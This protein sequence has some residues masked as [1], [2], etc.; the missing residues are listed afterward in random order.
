MQVHKQDMDGGINSTWRPWLIPPQD[1]CLWLQRPAA[2]CP[3]LPKLLQAAGKVTPDTHPSGGSSWV[4]EMLLPGAL[5]PEATAAPTV[6]GWRDTADVIIGGDGEGGIT[7]LAKGQVAQ[8]I[9]NPSHCPACF[10]LLT[11]LSVH[12]MTVGVS[13]DIQS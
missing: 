11:A 3:A 2:H 7:L 5:P 1:R 12:T 13:S 8:Q 10:A 4:W 6:R 9:P